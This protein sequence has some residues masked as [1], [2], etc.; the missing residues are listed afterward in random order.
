MLARSS[1]RTSAEH[2]IISSLFEA[3]DLGAIHAPNRILMAPLTRGRASRDHVPTALMAE[4]YAQRASAGLI[5][6]EATGISQQGL[7]WPYAPGIWSRE[8]VKA[9][10]PIVRAVHDAGGRIVCQLWHMGRVVHPDFLGGQAPVSASATT[11]PDRAHTYRGKQR[12]AQARPLAVEE[13]RV[14][15]ED[16]RRAAANAME[17]GFDGVQLHA[18]NG[19]LVDQFLR[20]GTNLRADLYGGPAAN[21]V[22]LLVEVTQALIRAAGADRTGVRLSPNDDAQGCGDS[23]SAALFEQT[24]IALAKLNIAFLEM[25]ASRPSSSFRPAL[26]QL[27]PMIRRAFPN[28]L[29]LNS[30]YGLEDAQRAL[31]N[32]EADAIAFGRPFIANPDLPRRFAEDMGLNAAHVPTFYSQGHAGYT[33]YPRVP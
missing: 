22:R 13:I 31:R 29:V 32:G 11:A 10:K 25:R 21:R 14:L 2:A 27:T 20:D 9:W 30:D 28:P 1:V 15:I 19:Y 26:R 33:N 24:V 4:Y 6:S 8:Q 7:G 3:L 16:Y 12:Y 18:A 23:E 5:I 17:A